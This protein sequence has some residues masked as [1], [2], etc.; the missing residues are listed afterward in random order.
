MKTRLIGAILAIVLALTG[1]VVLTGYVK[2]A[3]VRAAAGAKLVPVYVIS[4]EIPAGTTGEQVQQYLT[5][6][7]IQ[8]S[9]VVPGH[10]T[11]L[12]ALT[13]KVADVT[14]QPGEQLIAS[15][16]VDPAKRTAHGD[17][18]LPTGMQAVTVALPVEHVVGGTVKPGDTV[19]VVISTDKVPASSDNP[20]T[21]QI[22]HKVLVT[23]VQEGTSTPPSKG[24]DTP[25][26][27]ATAVMVT[28]ALL[29]PDV[30]QLVW[31]QEWGSVWLTI[32]PKEADESGSR[33][34]NGKVVFP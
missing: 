27:P 34:V 28:L 10:V 14:L 21:K 20:I 33:I 8:A 17:V 4:A 16:W 31:G 19:G 11:K 29:T 30:E 7:T 5:E 24:A 23:A 18:A 13:G 32:E 3:D 26:Q 12:S 25:A 9:A 15:R 6:K 2:G 1:S 22:L